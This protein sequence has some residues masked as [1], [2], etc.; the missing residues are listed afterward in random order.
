MLELEKKEYSRSTAEIF[1]DITFTIKRQ[2]K[3]AV[4]G[5]NGA[6][7]STLLKIIAGMTNASTGNVTTGPSIGIGYFGQHTIE[8]LNLENTIFSEVKEK[9]PDRTDGFIRNVLAAFL[10]KGDDV[11]KKI[12]YLSGGEK[13][14]VVLAC[15]LSAPLNF[16][17]LDE[18]TN[19]LDIKSREVILETLKNY[20][21]T[22]MIVSH[23][24]F[25]LRHLADQVLEIDNGKATIF[26]GN[27]L[28]YIERK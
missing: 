5:V 13:A 23:D 20:Q 10:F 19:H 3:I 18:P 16:L 1:K 24:R 8:V 12:K 11:F 6:G 4:V 15:I 2:K 27:Y 14:R 28:E 25:F 26:P 22:I 21:G 17:I 9:L 7:K